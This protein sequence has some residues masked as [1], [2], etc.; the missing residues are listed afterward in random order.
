MKDVKKSIQKLWPELQWIK[1]EKLRHKTAAVWQTALEKSALAVKDLQTIPFTLLAPCVHVSFMEHK[2]AVVHMAKS[3][4]EHFSNFLGA[5]EQLCHTDAGQ[6]QGTFAYRSEAV[7][8]D[9]IQ[10]SQPL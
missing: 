10:S 8:R 9:R 3:C 2:R 1:N 4:G 6:G 7:I 5:A